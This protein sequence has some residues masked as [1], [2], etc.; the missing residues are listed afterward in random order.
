LLEFAAS[1]RLDRANSLKGAED[2]P[3]PMPPTVVAPVDVVA[4]VLA[5]LAIILLAARLVGTLF[6]KLGQ[7]RVVGEIIA[8]ILIGPT[9]LGGALAKAPLPGVPGVAGRGLVDDLFPLQAFSFLNLIGQVALVFYM[10]LVGV[11]LDQR[12]LKGKGRQ[13]LIVALAVTLVPVGLGFI[14]GAV[15]SGATWKPEGVSSTAF[16]LFMGAGVSVTAFPVMARILQ[17][18]ELLA[19]PLGAVGVGAAAIVT[20]IMFL[21]IAAASASAKGSGAVS[22]VGTKLLLVVGLILVLVVIVR[23]ALEFLTRGWDE[24]APLPG[25]LLAGLLIGAL[26]TGLATDRILGAGLVGGFFFGMVV[27]ARPGLAEQV[28]ARMSDAVI[29]FF[30]PVFLAVSGL[31]TDLTLINGAVLAGSALFITAMIV[32]KLGVGYAAG[33]A[34]GLSSKESATLGALMNCRGLLILVVALIGLQLGVITP[35]TQIVFVLGAIVTTMM[36]GPLVDLFL[37]REEVRRATLELSVAELS[38]GRRRASGTAII[39]R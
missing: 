25:N 7:P 20:V 23:P 11:E 27:P 9:I 16:S 29:L 22:G 32:G 21:I 1:E 18:K 33:R 4:Y 12:L 38:E 34:V 8:G 10:F 6:E 15:L 37:P 28:I 14:C 35:Q 39:A 30:L 36:T 3:T 13:M 17:E 2:M 31:R 19:S 5:A 26:I 24:S